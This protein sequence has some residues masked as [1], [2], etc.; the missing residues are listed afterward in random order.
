[1]GKR[2][3]AVVN[4]DGVGE[5][6]GD[7]L[8]EVVQAA[9]KTADE[10]VGE[11]AELEGAS[12]KNGPEKTPDG[13]WTA[14]FLTGMQNRLR[15]Q[16]VVLGKVPKPQVIFPIG[17]KLVPS[18]GSLHFPYKGGEDWYGFTTAHIYSM[19]LKEAERRLRPWLPQNKSWNVGSIVGQFLATNT[20]TAKIL[21]TGGEQKTHYS[22]STGL[23]LMPHQM[24]FRTG[25]GNGPTPSGYNFADVST[26]YS[27]A[28]KDQRPLRMADPHDP[29]LPERQYTLC[30]GASGECR[31][32][33]LVYAGQNPVTED[34][35]RAKLGL[36]YALLNEPHAF[37][38]VLAEACRNEF[39]RGP[40]AVKTDLTEVEKVVFDD[41]IEAA[42]AAADSHIKAIAKKPE[43][44]RTEIEKK[45]LEH[46][47]DRVRDRVNAEVAATAADMR[48]LA[49]ANGDKPSMMRWIR[50]NVLSDVPWEKIIP[51]WFTGEKVRFE[52]R[53]EPWV[54]SWA[55]YY[56]YTKNPGRKPGPKYD[57]TLSY[58][59]DN[60]EACVWHLQ[61]GG[62]VAAVFVRSGTVEKKTSAKGA[63]AAKELKLEGKERSEFLRSLRKPYYTQFEIAATGKK[64]GQ[65]EYTK[66]A[67]PV[68]FI[69]F[70]EDA[71]T[72][73][74]GTP[75]KGQTFNGKQIR[76]Y[77]VINGDLTDIRGEDRK[78][79][80][81]EH[82]GAIVH[83]AYKPSQ[84]P[85]YTT[86]EWKGKTARVREMQISYDLDQMV[87]PRGA[88]ASSPSRFTGKTR[89]V[90]F[91]IA[92]RKIPGKAGQE[93]VL[94]L[95]G[96]VTAAQSMDEHFAMKIATFM[97]EEV[98]GL[99]IEQ[100]EADREAAAAARKVGWRRA[101]QLIGPGG[102]EKS[103][104]ESR[105]VLKAAARANPRRRN[106]DFATIRK[107]AAR[108][109]RKAAA[110]A[111]AAAPHLAQGAKTIG[112]G[113]YMAARDVAHDVR[114]AGDSAFKGVYYG[115]QAAKRANPAVT[116][117]NL[118][119]LRETFKGAE[120]VS[121]RVPARDFSHIKR[122]MDAGLLEAVDGGK[123]LRL[124]AA[125][126]A[127]LMQRNPRR[128]PHQSTPREA[129][130]DAWSEFN[131]V[132]IDGHNKHF[133]HLEL[134]GPQGAGEFDIHD[135]KN[136][137]VF[138]VSGVE[139]PRFVK[140]SQF[141]EVG[142]KYVPEKWE[143][144]PANV[145]AIENYIL[146]ASNRRPDIRGA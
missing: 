131:Y 40:H 74:F 133:A 54:P 102:L 140:I 81:V 44:Q 76:G 110:G 12:R 15:E 23:N 134:G 30:A 144:V 46:F 117:T 19:P 135:H 42:I 59:G 78:Q 64:V 121:A 123:M 13:G 128:N 80:G 87:A 35:F 55:G 95:D 43:S 63:A 65:R 36:S 33:C 8:R 79:F 88:P 45:T 5:L 104:A 145:S 41:G 51:D 14:Y 106:P 122:C 47:K 17:Q 10:V 6:V 38:R 72:A 120:V 75:P 100:A 77:P 103:T 50:L 11:P 48:E 39:D 94:M 98:K 37:L 31:T 4:G 137:R 32:A 127:A 119:T 58:A 70:P 146:A 141:V 56:D 22:R 129:V 53:Y 9:A 115:M 105:E 34:S 124:T 84:A 139:H 61:Q 29:S 90:A 92:V 18:A 66:A 109:G 27:L 112:R 138:K 7:N 136:D 28:L 96:G 83:L 116:P 132:F 86:V 125:G 99:H 108:L 49:I 111:R 85:Y 91:V 126:R 2:L 1:M 67:V 130:A 107:H 25:E 142:G 89:R 82:C 24:A 143:W 26:E 57:L 52:G 97:P 71:L 62:K 21:G 101:A 118:Y 69:P 60:Q 113:A 16:G 73:I 68:S 3:F 93:P 114:R 20:K